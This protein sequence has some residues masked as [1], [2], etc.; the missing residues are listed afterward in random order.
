M[1]FEPQ[2]RALTTQ[3]RPDRQVLMWS[4]TWPK[5]VQTLA[6]EFLP[7]EKL[8]I[9]V[10]DHDHQACDSIT[11]VVRI[12]QRHEK[13]ELLNESLRTY[14]QQYSGKVL[15]FTATKRMAD[16]LARGL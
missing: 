4:A 8:T 11:Q 7:N 15:V 9:K 5:E 12:V 16:Q 1:G 10:G 6:S 2:I 3:I 13:E 14:V